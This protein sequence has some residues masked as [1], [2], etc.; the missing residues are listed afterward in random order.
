[1]IRYSPDPLPL[2]SLWI[3]ERR[4]LGHQHVSSDQPHVAQHHLLV[5]DL[6]GGHRQE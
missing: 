3:V 4:E 5:W 1:M 2:Y 6:C